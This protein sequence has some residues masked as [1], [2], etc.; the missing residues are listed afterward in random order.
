MGYTREFAMGKQSEGSNGEEEED[1]EEGYMRRYPMGIQSE[2]GGAMP[3]A[4]RGDA[5]G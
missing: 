3:A 5:N 1:E 2:E 4:M